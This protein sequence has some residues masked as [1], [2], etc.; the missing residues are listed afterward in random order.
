MSR[1]SEIKQ[2]LKGTIK[3]CVD[4]IVKMQLERKLRNISNN[5]TINK[6]Y[7]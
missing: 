7:V 3:K 6:R 1:T 4:P 5:E 2:N